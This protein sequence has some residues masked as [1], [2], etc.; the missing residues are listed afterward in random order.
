MEV[1]FPRLSIKCLLLKVSLFMA[2]FLTIG[3][4]VKF[5]IGL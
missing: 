4:F 2:D 5:E 1:N 3:A